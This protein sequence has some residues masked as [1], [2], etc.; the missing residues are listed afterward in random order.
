MF[1]YITKNI[2]TKLLI[3]FGLITVLYVVL[4]GIGLDPTIMITTGYIYNDTNEYIPMNGR[5]AVYEFEGYEKGLGLKYLSMFEHDGTKFYTERKGSFPVNIISRKSLFEYRLYEF[6]HFIAGETSEYDPSLYDFSPYNYGDI[7]SLW[8]VSSADDIKS[9]EHHLL[10]YKKHLIDDRQEIADFYN[11]ITNITVDKPV[12]PFK[13]GIDIIINLN[14]GR[15]I[16]GLRYSR[17]TDTF[18]I[19]GGETR[20]TC[21]FTDT[22][23]AQFEAIFYN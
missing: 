14:D 21:H 12:E 7:L 4:Y 10:N 22:Q 18:A 6:S 20:L 8:G 3:I 5:I 11:I 17:T 19:G 13:A 1:K 16:D 23:A 9:I 2:L 15:Q